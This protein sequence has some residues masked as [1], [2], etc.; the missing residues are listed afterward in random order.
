M[1]FN[2]EDRL[3]DMER[4]HFEILKSQKAMKIRLS[5]NYGGK[6]VYIIG[7]FTNWDYMIKLHKT[8]VGGTPIFDISMYVKAG[9]YYYYFVVDGKIRF[10]PDQP[11]T[12]HKS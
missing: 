10:A 5:W 3:D 2:P 6:E 9:M 4:E 11:S 1:Y 8:K 7:S 12:I